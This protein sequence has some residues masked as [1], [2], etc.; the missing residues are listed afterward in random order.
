MGIDNEVSVEVNMLCY[1]AL[2][3]V[4]KIILYFYPIM[5]VFDWVLKD[6]C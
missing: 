5:Q 2:M 6:A 4:F 3:N 1:Y